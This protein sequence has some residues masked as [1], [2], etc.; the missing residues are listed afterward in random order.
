MEQLQPFDQAD[1]ETKVRATRRRRTVWTVVW[2]NG[3]SADR[4]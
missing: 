3:G 2:L 4:P 1:W